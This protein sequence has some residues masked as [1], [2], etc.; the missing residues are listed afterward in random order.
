MRR[1]GGGIIGAG[2]FALGGAFGNLFW[3]GAAFAQSST[4]VQSHYELYAA[5]LHVADVQTDFVLG[6]ETYQMHMAYHTTGLA[7]LFAHGNNDSVVSGTWHG[8][9]AAP[10]RLLAE[11]A[12]KGDPRLTDIDFNGGM[13][14][15][16]RLLPA[17]ADERQPVPVALK[18]GSV[19]T[20][21][22]MAD[23]MR[24]VAQT[25]ACDLTLRTYDGHRILRFDAQTVEHELLT[26][27]RGSEFNGSALRCDFTATPIAGAKVD[28]EADARIFRGSVWLASPFAAAPTMPVRM[29]FETRWFGDAVLY[30][31]KAEPTPSSM[32]AG[33]R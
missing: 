14:V 26:P 2:F 9:S 24:M 33:T 12:L 17:D 11:G 13:P 32:I 29:A 27:Y 22:A 21:S 31:I 10:Q 23:L 25:G 6:P 18:N 8:N 16:R 15:V 3:S 5:G 4:P 7:S 1:R 19:D 28:E 20:L 30:L